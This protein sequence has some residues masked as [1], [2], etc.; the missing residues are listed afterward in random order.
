MNLKTCYR[1][2]DVSCEASVNCQHMSQNAMPATEFARCHHFTQPWQC[3]SQKTRNV[4]SAAPAT[5]NDD[6]G[7]QSVAPATKTGTLLLETWQKYC[8]CHTKRLSTRDATR[9]NVTKYHACHAKR[10]Y[11]TCETSKVTTVAKLAIGTAI[12]ASHGRPRTVANGCKMLRNV[13]RT[14]PQPPDPQSETG[15]LATHSGKNACDKPLLVES[16]TG[17]MY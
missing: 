8:A 14:H 3:D 1:K 15:T 4:E 10:G 13:E 5:R 12:R 7:R 2:I 6:G 9:L 16:S 17:S 11:A